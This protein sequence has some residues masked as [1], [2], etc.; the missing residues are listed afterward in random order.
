MLRGQGGGEYFILDQF[1]NIWLTFI[2]PSLISTQIK[3]RRL[4]LIS[5]DSCSIYSVS[6]KHDKLKATMFY[7]EEAWRACQID[8][9]IQTYFACF[10]CLYPI[11][12]QHNQTN[13]F[14]FWL[15]KSI[16]WNGKVRGNVNWGREIVVFRRLYWTVKKV[17]KKLLFH[18]WS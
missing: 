14:F 18:T 1:L 2:W 15:W 6:T 13:K 8:K 3:S 9:Q 17:N 7:I 4:I 12:R 5:K 16:N 11:K 10:V